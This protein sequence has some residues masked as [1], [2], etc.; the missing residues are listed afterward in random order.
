MQLTQILFN[1]LINALHASPE[2]ST[3]TT[4]IDNDAEN[5]FVTIEDQGHGIAENIKQKIFEPFFTTK[6][7]N[8]GAGLGLSV[9]HG[10]VKNHNGEI[11]VKNNKP[12]G[13]VFTVKLPLK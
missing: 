2:K 1:L 12:S 6:D 8:A 7:V 11:S 10:I 3:I 9:V 5:L 4:I 13:T